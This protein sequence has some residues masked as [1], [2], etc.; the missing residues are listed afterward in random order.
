MMASLSDATDPYVISE[1]LQNQENALI[2]L[3]QPIPSIV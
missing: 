1:H 2:I 3:T